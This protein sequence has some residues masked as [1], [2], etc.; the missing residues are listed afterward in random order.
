MTHTPSS[1]DE[2]SALLRTFAG[3]GRTVGITGGDVPRGPAAVPVDEVLSTRE[4]DAIID[5][6]PADQIV[7]VE[8]GMTLAKL[9][10][11]L[12]EQRQRLALDPPM[13]RRATVGGTV[14]S[15]SYGA[16]RTRFGTAKDAIVGMT[17]VRADG[18]IARGGGKVVKNVAGFDIPKLMIGTYGTLAMIGTVT[19]RLHP[20]PE[21]SCE[22][23]FADCDAAALRGLCRE[24]LAAQLEPSAIY[25]IYAGGT[26]AC[27]IR[28]EG[29]PQGVDSQR[30]AL[31]TI[32]KREPCESGS[33]GEA[34]ERAR[35]SGSVQLKVS[36]PASLLEELHAQAIAPL[37]AALEHPH[38][39]LYPSL[40]VGFIGGDVAAESELRGRL[41]A[42]RA[43]AESTGGS[44]VVTEAPE[45]LHRA[46]DRWGTPPPSFALMRSLKERFDPDRRLQPSGFVGGL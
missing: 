15:A 10:A 17:I 3:N 1:L 14:A 36:A 19:F 16:L 34:H 23:V 46:I 32:A 6:V 38:A 44:L 40:G 25:A 39:A 24:M 9:Q 2:A 45:T 11:T 13:A 21:S 31:L 4:L 7:T 18:T 37:C 43:W 29:F 27:A 20:L 5:Y 41:E 33:L 30:A 8:A 35:S 12:G 22:V 28:F 26:Y 42:A